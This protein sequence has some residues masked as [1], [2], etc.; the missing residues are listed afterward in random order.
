VP[1]RCNSGLTR[2]VCKVDRH[3]NRTVMWTIQ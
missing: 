3:S 2:P 1:Q